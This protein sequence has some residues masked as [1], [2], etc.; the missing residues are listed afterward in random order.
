MEKL[1]GGGCVFRSSLAEE[2]AQRE[3]DNR[4]HAEMEKLY[5]LIQGEMEAEERTGRNFGFI[6]SRRSNIQ[7]FYTHCA[8]WKTSSIL[9]LPILFS[10]LSGIFN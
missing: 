8:P 2:R 9:S 3:F 4:K 5:T 6:S 7:Y 10:C 1:T